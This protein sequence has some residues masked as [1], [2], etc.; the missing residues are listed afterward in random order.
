MKFRLKKYNLNLIGDQSFL[1]GTFF[2]ASAL[3]ISGIFFLFA[4][5]ISFYKN[6]LTIFNDKWNYPLFFSTGLLIVSTLN[7]SLFN[8]P[9]EASKSESISIIVGIFNWIPL[10]ISFWA[11][12]AYLKNKSQREL[13]AK[14]LIAGSIPVLISCIL[15]Y[16]FNIYGP[17]ETLNGLIIWFQK[18]IN[19]NSGVS[20]LFSNQN[21]AGFWLSAI[22]PFSIYVLRNIKKRISLKIIFFI[23]S[24]FIFYLTI[25]TNSRNGLISILISTTFLFKIKFF[26]ILLLL[27]LLFLVIYFYLINPSITGLF[28]PN[29]FLPIEM[30]EQI[31]T[32]KLSNLLSFPRFEIWS[33][34]TKLIFERPFLGWGASTF[35]I[36][37][38]LKGGVYEIQHTHNIPL[39]LAY[40]FG[41]PLSI[42]LCTFSTYLLFRGWRILLIK[43]KN[44]LDINLYWLTSLSVIFISHI[45]DISYYDGKISLLIWILL[46]G[47]KCFI[48][49]EKLENRSC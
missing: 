33:K 16:W 8:P 34:A 35:A 9:V 30:L 10:F 17:F 42:V 3:P 24:L 1:I 31:Y 37:Y 19:G 13:F 6:K 4:I 41:I 47:V 39:E 32:F 2:L 43:E 45:N 27:I 11:F 7:S 49:E 38:S 21:Y 40:N 28:Y 29:S 44:Y 20:G 18:P 15:Q 14:Y 5:V 22:W 12:Q 48:E 26:I 23:I 36:I 25:L 46:A